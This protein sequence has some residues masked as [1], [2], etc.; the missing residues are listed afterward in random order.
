MRYQVFGSSKDTWEEESQN[1]VSAGDYDSWSNHGLWT[2]E[3]VDGLTEGAVVQNIFKNDLAED[4]LDGRVIYTATNE[5]NNTP[6]YTPDF[7]Q[8]YLEDPNNLISM[9]FELY[10]RYTDFLL[11]CNPFLAPFLDICP[12]FLLFQ[13]PDFA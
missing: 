5:S 7:G 11:L 4:V 9:K 1:R 13:F 8:I 10:Q 6:G 3:W 2:D 12:Q